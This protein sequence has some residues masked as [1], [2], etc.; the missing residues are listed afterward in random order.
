MKIKRIVV[1]VKQGDK[2]LYVGPQD[3]YSQRP[4]L[5]ESIEFAG[6]F[7]GKEKEMDRVISGF[8]MPDSTYYAFS[9][10]SVDSVEI[11]EIEVEIQE[12][13]RRPFV[14]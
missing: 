12:V 9:A 8:R 5:V 11:V 14:R 2:T 6:N 13:A 1:E 4:E 3:K 7:D 10:I